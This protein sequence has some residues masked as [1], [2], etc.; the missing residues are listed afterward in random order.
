MRI[1]ATQ[2][3][4]PSAIFEKQLGFNASVYYGQE[5]TMV[6]GKDVLSYLRDYSDKYV[7]YYKDQPVRVNA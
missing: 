1:F 4:F 5:I 6:N 3:V 2:G 7:G